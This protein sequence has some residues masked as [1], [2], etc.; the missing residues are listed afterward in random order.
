MSHLHPNVH[1]G[2]SRENPLNHPHKSKRADPRQYRSNGSGQLRIIHVHVTRGKSR[3]T[4]L[5]RPYKSKRADP[6]QY[7]SNGSRQ[8][9]IIHVHVTKGKSRANPLTHP[10]KSKRAER[11]HCRAPWIWSGSHPRPR[12][13]RKIKSKLSI[14][15][16]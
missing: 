2:K 3:A 14:N 8:L 11:T 9:R 6:S 7:R 13:E 5:T 1:K 10:D 12:Y 4:P 15:Q 16:Q